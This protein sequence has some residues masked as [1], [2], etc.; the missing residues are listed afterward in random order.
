MADDEA[1]VSDSDIVLMMAMQ[2]REGLRL[3]IE[4]YGGRLKAFLYKR[5]GGVLQE[6]ELAEALNVAFYNIWRFADRYDESKG[7]LP[8]WCVRIAQRAAQSII[9][10]ESRYR[11]KNLEYDS[12]YDPAG[13]PP[14]EDVVASEDRSDDPRVDALH[15]AI[16]GLPPLQRAITQADLAADGLADAGRLAEIHGTSKNSIYVSR[17]K[18]REAL[19][20]QAEQLSRQPAG[21]RR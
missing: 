14:G 5:F 6:G 21:K 3:L 7:S 10:R 8:S 4:Q 12:M 18:A 9:R 1:T 19:K 2:D 20:K 11:S 13:D 17:S 16:A 15:K